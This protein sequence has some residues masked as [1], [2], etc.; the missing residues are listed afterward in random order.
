MKI[1][2]KRPQNLFLKIIAE[3]ETAKCL[4]QPPNITLIS[5]R[6]PT[7]F[8]PS[9]VVNNIIL[10]WR[11]RTGE[12]N[13]P[14]DFKPTCKKHLENILI[15]V[16]FLFKP[17]CVWDGV[18]NFHHLRSLFKKR[19]MG[20]VKCV[21][22]YYKTRC[23]PSVLAQSSTW[24][25]SLARRSKMIN[26]R[27]LSLL[28]NIIASKVCMT[29]SARHALHSTYTVCLYVSFRFH[30]KPTE[31][32]SYSKGQT[33]SDWMNSEKILPHFICPSAN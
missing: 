31:Y 32:F 22:V 3:M 33:A 11:M 12:F 14:W 5:L 7:C 16:P 26:C 15:Y 2:G 25:V 24:A 4:E 6:A 10:W 1:V 21:I 29:S 23:I 18:H 28:Y 27:F 9:S 19:V 8:T 20:S 13:D 17:K 30:A